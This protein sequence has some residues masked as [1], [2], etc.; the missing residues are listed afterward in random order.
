MAVIASSRIWISRRDRLTMDAF[1]IAIVGMA[2]GA[3]LD[4]S[5]LIPFPRGQFMDLRVAVFTLDVVDEMGACVVLSPFLLMASMT[6]DRLCVDSPSLCFQMGLYIRDIPMAAITG[7]GTVNGLSEFPF[8]DF[9]M[10]TET[11]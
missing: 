2:G 11:F 6:G 4:H 7:V 3:R 5:R 8:A 1:S 10:T 9:G